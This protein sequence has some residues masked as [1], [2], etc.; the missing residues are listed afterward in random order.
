MSTATTDPDGLTPLHLAALT[1]D[2]AGAERLLAAGEKVNAKTTALLSSWER[3]HNRVLRPSSATFY[4]PDPRPE[5][6]PGR[7]FDKGASAL[8]MAAALGHD[9]MVALLLAN[10]ARAGLKDGCGGTAL[11]LAAL[12][13]HLT[14]VRRLLG[15]KTPINAPSK[16][17]KSARFYDVGMTPMLAAL[18][19]GDI[20][21]VQAVL[22]AGGELSARTKAGCSAV[23]FAARGGSVQA[24]E[25]VIEAGVSAAEPGVYSNF[26]LVEAVRRGHLEMVGRLLEL[27][28]T[29]QEPGGSQAP[30]RLATELNLT[31]IRQR[32]LDGGARPLQ[33]RSVHG[34]AR[35]NDV[36]WVADYLD[37]GGDPQA[38]ESGA[39][40]LMTAAAQGHTAT[41]A[42]LIER[43]A[44]VGFSA[45]SGSALHWALANDNHDIAD[46]LLAAGADCSAV[47]EYGNQPLLKALG[48][49]APRR[50][51]RIGAMLRLGANPHHRNRAGVSAVDLAERMK[52]TE[53]LALFARESSSRPQPNVTWQDPKVSA[54][55]RAAK[56]GDSWKRLHSALW[57]ELVP[58]RGQCGTV[59][60]E[61]VRC[62]GKLTDEAYRNGNI[63]W[64]GGHERMVA[65]L[66]D[67][68]APDGAV[69][70]LP[71]LRGDLR[72][73]L[74]HRALDLSGDG[75]PH[76]RVNEAVVRWCQGHPTL[77]PREHDPLLDR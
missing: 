60:G 41:A 70:L 47:D 72:K 74:H 59:Q 23:F 56:P 35:R 8:H 3:P 63:N 31:A 67:T 39:T 76:Y 36:H 65:F 27:G 44:N 15:T 51:E 58:P 71:G 2:L 13:G 38:T 30:L 21:V 69:E 62:I 61:L 34:A 4:L 57:D 55:L 7:S 33:H 46:Q 75:S 50:L 10:K 11:H 49:R 53:T 32:L 1:G 6:G 43:G 68:L 40:P 26:P 42:L 66:R 12:G 16:V 29:T 22:Q 20:D 24:L 77:I 37:R 45:G 73:L 9:A 54:V 64:S 28:A 5:L 19:S 52:D 48:R 17:R 25:W 18:E 14:V